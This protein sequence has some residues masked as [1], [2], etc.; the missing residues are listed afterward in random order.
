[1]CGDRWEF[2]DRGEGESVVVDGRVGVAVG[3]WVGDSVVVGKC[4]G[5][6]W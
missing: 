5:V 4:V 2:G 6:R 1:M 3:R